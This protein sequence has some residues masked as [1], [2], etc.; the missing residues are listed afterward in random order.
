MSIERGSWRSERGCR[1]VPSSSTDRNDRPAEARRNPTSRNG[2]RKRTSPAS[3]I[4]SM[5]SGTPKKQVDIRRRARGGRR[6]DTKR[7]GRL[8]GEHEPAVGDVPARPVAIGGARPHLGQQ[9][10]RRHAPKVDRFAEWQTD[11]VPAVGRGRMDDDVEGPVP[12]LG[13]SR[14]CGSRSRR[15]PRDG[16]AV[17]DDRRTRT[18]HGSGAGEEHR[19]RSCRETSR[20]L[21]WRC[22]PLWST[23]PGRRGQWVIEEVHGPLCA[24]RDPGAARLS[25]PAA[26]PRQSVPRSRT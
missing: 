18:A 14:T 3:A 9:R 19:A 20:G 6:Q 2:V 21:A 1:P 4:A 5:P 16:R 15:R 25:P 17:R 26:R 24:V 8:A 10:R 22:V 23:L 11:A 7:P 12:L 13:R